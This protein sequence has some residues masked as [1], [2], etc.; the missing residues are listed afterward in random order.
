ME[1]WY[2]I[3]GFIV[4]IAI[5]II[6]IYNSLVGKRNDVKNIYASVDVQLK[7]RYDLIPNLLSTVQVYFNHEKD[8]L[9]GIVKLREGAINSSSDKDKFNLNN[10]LTKALHGLN[11]RIESYP[12]LKSSENLLKLQNA[13]KDCEEEISAARRAYNSAVTIYNNACEM[14]PSNVVA[15]WFGFVKF[16]VFEASAHERENPDIKNLFNK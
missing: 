5:V 11:L 10:D 13:L 3:I 12:D 1:N 15:K 2:F 8:V 16:E 7:Q 9:E 6:A 4:C 14:F